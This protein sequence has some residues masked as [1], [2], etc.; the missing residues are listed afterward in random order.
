MEYT[1]L[2][3]TAK[4]HTKKPTQNFEF[5]NLLPGM[6]VDLPE[7]SSTPPPT[8]PSKTAPPPPLPS[9]Q[10]NFVYYIQVGSFRNLPEADQLKARLILQGFQPTIQRIPIKI[11]LTVFRVVLGPFNKELRAQQQ[12]KQLEKHKIFGKITLKNEGV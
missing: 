2:T 9:P 7:S 1:A 6:E 4:T 11:N 3:P 12:K 10:K 8:T 5:Y